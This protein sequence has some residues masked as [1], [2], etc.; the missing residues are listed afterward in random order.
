MLQRYQY[1]CNNTYF[2]NI[3]PNSYY[4]IDIGAAELVPEVELAC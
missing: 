1:T 2:T 4:S 3:L